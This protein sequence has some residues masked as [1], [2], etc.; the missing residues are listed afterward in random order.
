MKKTFIILIFY[1]FSTNI[2]IA[3]EHKCSGMKK[4]SKE[5]L[6][7]TAKNIKEGA[8]KKKDQVKEGSIKKTNQ[9]KEG[10]KKIFDKVKTKIKKNN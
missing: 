7:C 2:L 6:A 3:D 10:T 5:Y 1:L 9:I 8:V 4:L